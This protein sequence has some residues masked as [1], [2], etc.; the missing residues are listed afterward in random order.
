LFNDT[1]AL[2]IMVR[3]NCLSMKWWCHVCFV[4]D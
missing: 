4:L 2:Y 3:T 1:F